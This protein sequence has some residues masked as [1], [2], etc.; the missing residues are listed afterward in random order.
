MTDKKTE[1]LCKEVDKEGYYRYIKERDEKRFSWIKFFK[2]DKFKRSLFW[3]L[4]MTGMHTLGHNSDSIDVDDD[5]IEFWTCSSCGYECTFKGVIWEMIKWFL[6]LVGWFAF[7]FS[8]AENYM[9][10]FLSDNIAR[11]MIFFLIVHAGAG[12]RNFLEFMR[13]A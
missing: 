8:P 6:F 1:K 12:L 3:I 4:H 11:L 13:G 7:L 5:H 2:K 9:F 10:P